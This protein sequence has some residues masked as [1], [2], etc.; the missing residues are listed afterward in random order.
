MTQKG[1]I[2]VAGGAGF[3]GAQTCKALAK[4]GYLPVTLDNL[5]T[6]YAAAV[7]WGPLYQGD[8]RD[9]DLVRKIVEIGRAHV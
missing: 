6:G 5:S 3:I 2:L 7:R 4:A 1:A 9:R 8:I